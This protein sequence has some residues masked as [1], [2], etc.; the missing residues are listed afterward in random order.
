MRNKMMKKTTVQKEHDNISEIL[1][2][3][4]MKSK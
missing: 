4:G 2:K 1:M 3:K